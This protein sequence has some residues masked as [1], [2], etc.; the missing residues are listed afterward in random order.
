MDCQLLSVFRARLLEY[1]VSLLLVC[2]YFLCAVIRRINLHIIYLFDSF[3]GRCD[4]SRYFFD[5]WSAA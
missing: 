3:R 2:F 4:T 1:F 5:V